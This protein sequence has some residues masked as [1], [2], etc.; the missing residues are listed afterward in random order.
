[1][2]EEQQPQ[3]GV[4]LHTGFPNP[5][6][7]VSL[8]AL[9]LRQLLVMHPISTFVFRVQGKTWEKFG[10]FDTDVALVDRALSAKKSDLVIWWQPGEEG[11]LISRQATLPED[12]TIWGVV[13]SVVHQFRQDK[14]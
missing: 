7:D 10:I 2:E 14:R 5:A 12:A 13:T 8:S 3:D 1:M 11:F 4:S 6:S 9:D